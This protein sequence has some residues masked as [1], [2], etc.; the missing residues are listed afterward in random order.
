MHKKNNCVKPYFLISKEKVCNYL[1]CSQGKKKRVSS[2]FQ[3]LL[4]TITRTQKN[5]CDNIQ[6]H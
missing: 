6:T 5:M 3:T 1:S 2:S 4:E